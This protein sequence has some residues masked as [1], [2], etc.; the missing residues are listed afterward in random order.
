MRGAGVVSLV[1][2]DGM[3]EGRADLAG[4][5]R[6]S[7]FVLL[8]PPL[9]VGVQAIFL[10]SAASRSGAQLTIGVGVML[11]PWLIVGPLMAGWIRSRSEAAF[12]TFVANVAVAP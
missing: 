2:A 4:T 1:I 3:I 10:L 8:F 12:R 6:L 5:R 7:L 11:L 9:L